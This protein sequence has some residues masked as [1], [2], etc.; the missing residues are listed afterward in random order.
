MY[1]LHGY[2]L[3]IMIKYNIQYIVASHSEPWRLIK[4]IGSVYQW[5][6]ISLPS[7]KLHS[8]RNRKPLTSCCSSH[9]SLVKFFMMHHWRNLISYEIFFKLSSASPGFPLS[10]VSAC[11]TDIPS[12]FP[13]LGPIIVKGTWGT[14]IMT[15]YCILNSWQLLQTMG[16]LCNPV[17]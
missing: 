12:S 3:H 8:G 17:Q 9:Q 7:S 16:I 5:L 15:S 1:Y 11:F 6:S 4:G 2:E 14:I 10:S 13:A